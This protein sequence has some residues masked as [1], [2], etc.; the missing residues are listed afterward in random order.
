MD[1]NVDLGLNTL[2]RQF[3]QWGD[4]AMQDLY[5]AAA[6]GFKTGGAQITQAMQAQVESRLQVKKRSFAKSFRHKVYARKKDQPPIMILGSGIPWI[7]MHERGGTISGKMLIPFGARVGRKRFKQIIDALMRSGNAFFQRVKSG[8]VF[9][10]AENIAEN[11]KHLAR[12]KRTYRQSNKLKSL[13]R[14]TEVPIAELVTR[15]QI[16]R[17]LD[18]VKLV[19]SRLPQLRD[20]ILRAA[21]RRL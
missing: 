2:A 14:D 21:S 17:R 18:I 9:L 11:D 20:E 4:R 19:E 13:K 1:I 6:E 12:F 16:K 5:A 15:V 3:N 8:R 10:F 7:A